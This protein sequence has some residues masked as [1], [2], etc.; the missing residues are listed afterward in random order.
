MTPKPVH[1]SPPL[2]VNSIGQEWAWNWHWLPPEFL[3][4]HEDELIDALLAT[5]AQAGHHVS[6]ADFIRHYV[7]GCAQMY[8]FGGGALQALMGKLNAR[9]LLQGLQP[10]DDRTRDGSI[11]DELLEVFVGAEMTRRTFTNVCNIMRRHGF[12]G[13]WELWRKERGLPD[14]GLKSPASP[15]ARPGGGAGGGASSCERAP[16]FTLGVGLTWQEVTHRAERGFV[17]AVG[18]AVLLRL[19]LG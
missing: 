13:E 1:L 3:D 17:M 19:L 16:L 10:D 7:L 6:K 8:C 11:S 4:E 18:A 5:Y 2:A 12:V 15:S 9:G 14:L